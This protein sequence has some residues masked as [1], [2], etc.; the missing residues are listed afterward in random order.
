[1]RAHRLQAVAWSAA[2]MAIVDDQRD[3]ALG[4]KA[5]GDR[6]DRLVASGG[7][8][9]D[10]AVA[11]ESE[12]A[13]GGEHPALDPADM[14][15]DRERVEELIGDEQQ[16]TG[17]KV[18]DAVMPARLR[19]GLLLQIAQNWAGFYEMH[20]AR[21]ARRAHHPQRIGGEG[22]A[23]GTELGINR[24]IRRSRPPP[25]IGERGADHPAG[26]LAD[27][28]RCGEVALRAKRV[29]RCIIIAVARFHIG[30]DG[31]RSFGRDPLPKRALQRGHAPPPALCGRTTSGN[32]FST[33]RSLNADPAL[34]GCQHQVEPAEDHRQ[35]Q[36][37]THVEMGR[38]CKLDELVIG[39]A[40]ILD[41]ET[42]AAVEE[43]ERADELARI[44]AGPGPPEHEAKDAEQDDAFE[45]GLV[46]LAWMARRAEHALAELVVLL[47]A[48]RPRHRRRRAP[49]LL[50]DEVG[51]PPEQQAERDAAGDIIVDSEPVELLLVREIENAERSADHAAVERH[52]AVPKLQNLDR[53][54][55]VVAEI[56]EQ[57]VAE[58]ATEK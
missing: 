54:A 24:F 2:F 41:P 20:L 14:L 23:P 45:R 57:D 31:D 48:D 55:E 16:R 44:V 7:G 12:A 10:L 39:L 25:A 56:V 21:K 43:E 15:A 5:G 53:V 28:W 27:L 29:A 19:H 52:A 26:H 8:L 42:E 49:Q 11:V 30:F 37:L 22:P 51:D 35:R 32:A 38:L 46:E 47:E 33:G 6:A 36:P 40:D 58:A 17:G 9:D 4:R 1:M 3:A 50:V 13:S 34:G 18:V